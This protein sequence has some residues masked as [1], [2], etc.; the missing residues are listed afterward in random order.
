MNLARL[1]NKYFNDSQ[2]WKTIKED[3][4]A[5]A[6]TINLSLQLIRTL[7]VMLSPVIPFTSEKIFRLLNI[8]DDE[9]KKWEGCE[10]PKLKAGHKINQ[11]EI[12]FTKIED[13]T[14]EPYLKSQERK[15][16]PESENKENKINI[17]EFKKVEIR[18]AKILEAENVPK[19]KKLLKLKVDLGFEKRQVIA[20][21][22]EFYKPEEIIGKK[23]LVVSNLKEAKLMNEISQGMILAV[24]DENK[25][26]QLVTVDD[27]LPLGS[28]LR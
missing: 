14:I 2:P 13:K 18:V 25:N 6:T 1:A 22:A 12:I 17:D 20:G 26:L 5:C 19:S 8:E 21:I 28:V 11:P 3:P 24:E 27:N 9:L 10:E 7:A 23:V 16:Q 4:E 15:E